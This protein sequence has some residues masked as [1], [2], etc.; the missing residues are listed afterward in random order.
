MDAFMLGAYLK[1][2]ALPAGEYSVVI[3]M[4]KEINASFIG[5]EVSL[6]TGAYVNT[7]P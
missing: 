4:G 5:V 1:E 2:T 7:V 6:D 3:S